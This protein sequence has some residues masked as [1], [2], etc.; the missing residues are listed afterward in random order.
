MSLATICPLAVDLFIPPPPHSL[1]DFFVLALFA[2]HQLELGRPGFAFV[3][4]THATRERDNTFR[5][6]T[7]WTETDL[8]G[9]SV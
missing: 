2:G 7:Q 6:M 4:Q 9:S 1:A 3:T 8:N 5:W